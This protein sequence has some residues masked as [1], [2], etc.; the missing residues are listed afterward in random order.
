MKSNQLAKDANACGSDH[1][2]YLGK[3]KIDS[4]ADFSSLL[5]LR[6]QYRR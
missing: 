6:D 2:G 1:L 5:H 3:L 4:N